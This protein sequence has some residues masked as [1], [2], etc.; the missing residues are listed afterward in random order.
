MGAAGVTEELKAR[1]PMRWVGL[2][3]TLKVQVEETIFQEL[4]FQESCERQSSPWRSFYF[5]CA[6]FLYSNGNNPVLFRNNSANR[7]EVE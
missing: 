4:I 5:R 7:L 2:M 6:F 3:N 1:D